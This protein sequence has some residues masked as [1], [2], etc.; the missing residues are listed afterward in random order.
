MV[1]LPWYAF[2]FTTVCSCD[3]ECLFKVQFFHFTTI[4]YCNQENL[5]KVQLTKECCFVKLCQDNR[6]RQKVYVS[7][8]KGIKKPPGGNYMWLLKSGLYRLKQSGFKWHEVLKVEFVRWC[9]NAPILLCTPP[10]F[11]LSVPFPF[12]LLSDSYSRTLLQTISL[13]TPLNPYST[14]PW[15]SHDSTWLSWPL[16]IVT[17]LLSPCVYKPCKTPC[18][19][20]AQPLVF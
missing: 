18:S 17:H 1:V 10:P 16:S 14:P 7:L 9:Y 4:C 11:S 12:P 15:L 13:M 20:L 5:Y 3:Q 19:S 2:H 8:P 6:L